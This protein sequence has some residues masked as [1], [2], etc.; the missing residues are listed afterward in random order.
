MPRNH[1]CL[2]VCCLEEEV[3]KENLFAKSEKNA[4]LFRISHYYL[5]CKSRSNYREACFLFNLVMYWFQFDLI[6]MATAYLFPGEPFLSISSHL[7]DFPNEF[8]YFILLLETFIP[9]DTPDDV[10]YSHHI[11]V[12]LARSI[13]FLRSFLFDYFLIKHPLSVFSH[14]L[15]LLPIKVSTGWHI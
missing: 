6:A 1:H 8:W 5:S 13:V 12:F 9:E 14:P 4:N 11:F 10:C 2:F 7:R 3:W 15:R